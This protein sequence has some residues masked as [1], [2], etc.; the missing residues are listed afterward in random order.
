[1]DLGAALITLPLWSTW[2]ARRTL[3]CPWSVQPCAVIPLGWLRGRYGP[4]ARRPVGDVVSLD[5]P[6]G[7]EGGG[8]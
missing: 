7:E 4:T 1:M 6:G 3:G 8:G 5:R 2:A